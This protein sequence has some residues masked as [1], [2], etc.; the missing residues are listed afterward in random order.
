MIA[1]V[2]KMKKTVIHGAPARS[3]ISPYAEVH[4]KEAMSW[5]LI[6]IVQIGKGTILQSVVKLTP[7]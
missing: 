7:F 3:H 2:S 1:K 5:R 4:L 6:A